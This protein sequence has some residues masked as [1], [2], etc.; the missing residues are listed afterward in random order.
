MA[1]R[2]KKPDA[3]DGARFFA[4]PDKWRQ[5]LDRNHAKADELW[6]GYH[7]KSSGTPSITWPESVDEALCYGWIDGIRKSIDDTRYKIRFTPRRT[8][9]IWSA[10]NIAR[11]AVLMKEGRMR[12]SGLAAYNARTDEKSRVY[13]YEQK[14]ASTL[15]DELERRFRANAKAWAFF[16]SQ[17][18]YYRKLAT[19]WVVSAKQEATRQRRLATLIEDSAAGRRIGPMRRPEK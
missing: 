15:G 6:V 2:A 7:K 1:V 11:V 14:D 13:T 9:S 5:W 4:T 16:E 17:P 8:G 18:P 10:V 12:P 3:A 19:R